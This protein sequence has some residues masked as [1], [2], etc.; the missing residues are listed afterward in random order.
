[1]EDG[2]RKMEDG[3]RRKTVVHSPSSIPRL[4]VSR[5]VPVLLWIAGIFYFSSRPNPLGFLP[6]SGNRRGAGEAAHF[7][8]Y[9]GLAALLYRALAGGQK[10]ARDTEHPARDNPHTPGPDPPPRRRAFAL[11]FAMALAYAVSDELHQSLVPG[12]GGEIVDV[13]YDVAGI[14]AALGFIWL[15]GRFLTS[16]ANARRLASRE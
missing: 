12:R 13:G 16:K 9:A 14:A 2:K 4:S 15:R 3:R 10:T 11:S 7:L 6:S 5:W 1:M 8:E